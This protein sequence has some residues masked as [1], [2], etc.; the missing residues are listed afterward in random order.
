MKKLTKKQSRFID[1]YL[2]D[3]NATKAYKEAFN[4]DYTQANANGSRLRN[5]PEISAEIDRRLSELPRPKVEEVVL[6][7]TQCFRGG[8]ENIQIRDRI[9][10]SKELMK[11]Y[12]DSEKKADSSA[13]ITIVIGDDTDDTED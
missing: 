6:F 3:F 2:M 11:Y 10:A 5:T 4:V 8:I 7:L 9:E 12:T 13:D 1:L